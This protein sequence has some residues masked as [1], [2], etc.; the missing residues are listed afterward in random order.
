LRQATDLW[1]LAGKVLIGER[2]RL[3]TQRLVA[4]R[5][6]KPVLSNVW[7]PFALKKGKGSIQRE[8]A[9]VL[10]LNS[11]PGLILLLALREETEGAWV[12]FK[13][14]T[15]AGLPVLDLDQLTPK[16]FEKL[17][18]A[19]DRLCHKTLRP[20]SEMRED[21]IRAEIDQAIEQALNLPDLTV[22]RQMLGL[23]P[24]MRLQRIPQKSDT[25]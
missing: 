6:A 25:R 18:G 16:Q 2:L 23:E 24:V 9:L 7:W 14:P 15:L 17:V 19:Y 4:V 13:K 3:N 12:D 21:D 8:K 20:L 22:L 11:T 1:P 5:L 10:W